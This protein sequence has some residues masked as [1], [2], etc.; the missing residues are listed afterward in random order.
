MQVQPPHEIFSFETHLRSMHPASIPVSERRTHWRL[1]PEGGVWLGVTLL[2]GIVGWWK[3]F[4]AVLLLAYVML[5]LLCMQIYTLWRRRCGWQAHLSPLPTVFAGERIQGQIT[6]TNATQ[7][8]ADCVVAM[9]IGGQTL[10]WYLEAVPPAQQQCI[11]WTAILRQRGRFPIQVQVRDSDRFGWFRRETTI[12]AGEMFV[13]PALGDI[14]VPQL[15]RWLELQASGGEMLTQT[16]PRRMTLEP[17]EVRGVRPYRPGDA[18]RAIHWRTSA[19][20]RQLMVREYDDTTCGLPV[21]L[22]LLP[23]TSVGPENLAERWEA[24]L[25]FATTVAYFWPQIGHAPLVLTI[26]GDSPHILDIP[27]SGQGLRQILQPL[28]DPAAFPPTPG[29]WASIH[30]KVRY[31]HLLLRT[32]GTLA[33]YSP[34]ALPI[35][36]S[37]QILVPLT[38]EQ[39]PPWYTPAGRL[40]GINGGA[41]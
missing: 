13:L 29:P 28:A 4:N 11:S 24:A 25:S 17:N 19:R 23:P 36:P 2:V 26:A 31:I 33:A 12:S 37:A 16:A 34:E 9:Q 32:E 35:A 10:R 41:V 15:R 38:L 39:L 21:L 20:R 18:L 6:V 40:V 5:G 8:R 22:T 3:S 30:R 1:S 7:L 14:D 27:P